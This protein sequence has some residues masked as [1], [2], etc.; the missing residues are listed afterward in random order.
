MPEGSKVR[1]ETIKLTSVQKEQV[2]K[3]LG[4][5][6]REDAY[7]VWIGEKDDE[8][9]GY[10]VILDV[11]GKERPITFMVAVSPEGKVSGLEVLVYRESRGSE[12]RSKRFMK[13]FVEKTIAAPLMLGRDVDSISGA[14]LSSRST[15]HAAKKALA[16]VNVVYGNGTQK[17]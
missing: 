15:A 13:Q 17:P 11:I 4:S 14:T 10:A 2:E 1:Q 5:G 8:P 7:T 6:I 9:A 16:L 3:L 12:I